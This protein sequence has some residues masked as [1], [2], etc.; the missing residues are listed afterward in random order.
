MR[1][2]YFHQHFSLPTGYQ[3]SRSAILASAFTKLGHKVLVVGGCCKG[4]D[5]GTVLSF[6][7][8]GRTALGSGYWIVQSRVRYSNYFSPAFRVISFLRYC[9]FSSGFVFFNKIGLI[10]ATTTPLTV[11]VPMFIAK[12]FRGTRCVFEVRDRWPQALLALNAV[13]ER[14]ARCLA[15]LEK[16]AAIAADVTLGL[17]PGANAGFRELGVRSRN[18]FLVPNFSVRN[19]T[20][21][22]FS[23]DFKAFNSV[24][25]IFVLYFGAH[26][27]ANGLEVL[28]HVAKTISEKQNNVCFV[29][30]GDGKEKGRL[31]SLAREKKVSNIMFI[32]AIPGRRLQMILRQVHIVVHCLA[33]GIEREDSA[34]PNKIFEAMRA[35]LPIVTN[36]R[37]W[38]ARKI[39]AAGAGVVVDVRFF[40][41]ALIAL[42]TDHERRREMGRKGKMLSSM[43]FCSVEQVRRVCSILEENLRLC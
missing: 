3:P 19:H 34:S 28:L 18:S 30:V 42:A 8:M 9:F 41:E 12:V 13:S 20:E 38:L 37:G 32:D 33:P 17:A 40:A 31:I 43:E 36:W 16:A 6:G 1:V 26:G 23:G 11:S 14:T 2:F 25:E 15:L 29:F 27:H 24:F 4:A 35:G 21:K 5:P 10:F 7:A 22:E 39:D